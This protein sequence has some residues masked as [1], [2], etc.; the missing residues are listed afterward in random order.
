MHRSAE[1]CEPVVAVDALGGDASAAVADARPISAAFRL[2]N[3]DV[4]QIGSNASSHAACIEV[5]GQ[6]GSRWT[7]S[8]GAFTFDPYAPLATP[9]TIFDLAS[10]TKVIAATT[11]TMRATD[12]GRLTLDDPV[13]QWL[14]DWRGSDRNHVTVRQ[15]LTHSAGLTAFSP[16]PA[17][18]DA[19]SS[20]WRRA[21][22]LD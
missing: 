20:D 7:A 4:R 5:G 9:D 22:R 15:L 6:D 16:R 17:A 18:G 21:M 19:P 2:F 3:L 10:L 11:L 1:I 12:A 14:P 8:A 13:A